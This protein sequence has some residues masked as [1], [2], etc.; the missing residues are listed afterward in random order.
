MKYI[1]FMVLIIIL[2]MTTNFVAGDG[3]TI[4]ADSSKDTENIKQNI[5]MLYQNKDNGGLW[6]EIYGLK[7]PPLNET[8]N[9]TIFVTSAEGKSKEGTGYIID[10][11][12]GGLY[13]TYQDDY[14]ETYPR[15]D[16]LYKV[17]S[18]NIEVWTSVDISESIKGYGTGE[19]IAN[20]MMSTF[21]KIPFLWEA[22]SSTLPSMPTP[23]ENSAFCDDNNYDTLTIPFAFA[24]A[25]GEKEISSPDNLKHVGPDNALCIIVP[26]KFTDTRF[27]Y[28]HF[29]VAIQEKN[30]YNELKLTELKQSHY[31]HT[32]EITVP[33]RPSG[34]TGNLHQGKVLGTWGDI[35]DTTWPTKDTYDHT[36]PISVDI[37]F[38]N[39]GSQAYSF[40]AGY[41]VQDSTGQWWDAPPQQTLATQTGENGSI[42]LQWQPPEAAPDGAYNAKVA[43]WNDRNSDTGLMEGEFDSR[44]KDN[45]FQLNPI[46]VTNV[47]QGKA[48]GGWNKTFGGQE[49]AWVRSVQKTSDLGYILTGTTFEPDYDVWLIKTDA[50]GNEAWNKTFDGS[51]L[52]GVRSIQQTNDDG[53]IMTGETRS[54]GRSTD[55][56]LI[57]TDADGNKI[58]DKT[59]D[60]DY[61]DQGFF[62]QQTSDGGYII[63]GK[64]GIGYA[65]VWLI[66]T[67]ADGNKTWDK[68]FDKHFD[69]EGYSVQQTSDGG[70]IVIGTTKLS[71]LN[72]GVWLIKTDA[73]GNKIWDK[74][75][76]DGWGYSVQQTNDDGYIVTGKT[77]SER[78]RSYD[79]LLTKTN[80][81][82]NEV[83]NKT[84]DGSK[85]DLGESVQ[86]TSDGGYIIRGATNTFYEGNIW[87]IKTDADGNKIWDKT[88]DGYSYDWVGYMST[89]SLHWRVHD[90]RL[91]WCL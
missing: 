46:E 66:K 37:G 83:W 1:R 81:D 9:Y 80:A 86:Q 51:G 35:T 90:H 40:W 31:H 41:S 2:L 13:F 23:P 55:V 61:G 10:M 57:K 58:W 71:P 4:S 76:E 87:L 39:I 78:T 44:T 45:A 11:M 74:T 5:E 3:G 29:F 16:Y 54:N 8:V 69:A 62:V 72:R 30:A 68:T 6:V 12:N 19:L 56:W 26:T 59:F 70:Y 89:A 60:G 52:G 42:Q 25:R 27:T 38:K 91:D 7:N 34:V 33:V 20:T 53:Y 15:A 22:I 64:Q 24:G 77:Y 63:T 65:N 88:F 32:G 21:A 36:E 47:P 18:N 43:L 48:L 82:G 50:D 84:F 14:I 28:L 17:L 85:D 67:D 49:K 79:V 73:D 75:L